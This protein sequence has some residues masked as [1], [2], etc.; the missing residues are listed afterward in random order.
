MVGHIDSLTI[1]AKSIKKHCEIY[2]LHLHGLDKILLKTTQTD[3][4]G[5]KKNKMKHRNMFSKIR[6]LKY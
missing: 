3:T 1:T 6:K 2:S 5:T 4:K